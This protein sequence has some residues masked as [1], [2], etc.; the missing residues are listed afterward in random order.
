MQGGLLHLS[1]QARGEVGLGVAGRHCNCKI[2]TFCGIGTI[3]FYMYHV[4]SV[5]IIKV[6]VVVV[7]VRSLFIARVQLQIV[8]NATVMSRCVLRDTLGFRAKIDGRTV[9]I[10]CAKVNLFSLDE[11]LELRK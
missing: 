1:P 2:T 11:I 3:I 10:F 5:T 9:T 4:C 7:D 6:L 8:V